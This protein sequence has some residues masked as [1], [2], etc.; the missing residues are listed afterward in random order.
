M[1]GG[2]GVDEEVEDDLE[3][4]VDVVGGGGG[5]DDEEDDDV[6]E[7]DDEVEKE[8]NEVEEEDNQDVDDIVGLVL[9]LELE[10]VVLFADDV[11]GLML[12]LVDETSDVVFEAIDVLLIGTRVGSP[13]QVVVYVVHPQAV[14][15]AF[16]ALLTTDPV[17]LKTG[18]GETHFVISSL[19]LW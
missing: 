13:Y 19:L 8:D 18:K 5:T 1:E 7:E 15:V 3:D 6:E 9:V 14:L 17:G 10:L 4:V 16:V 12:M 11:V 2:G